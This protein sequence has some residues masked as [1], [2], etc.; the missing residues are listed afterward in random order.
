MP[1]LTVVYRQQN[2]GAKQFHLKLPW[3]GTAKLYREYIENALAIMPWQ[4]LVTDGRT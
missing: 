3:Q 4:N 1:G 2:I